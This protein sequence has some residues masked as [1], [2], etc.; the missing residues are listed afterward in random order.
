V[1]TSKKA[2]GALLASNRSAAHEYHLLQRLE[3]GIV[4]A[5]TEVKSA[6]A[7]RVN[8]KDAYAR[9]HDG[10]LWL[11]NAHFSPWTHASQDNHDPLRTRKLLVHARELR[12]L[13]R[14]TTSEG[15]TI[16][17]TRLYLK[18]GRIK[19]EIALA[20]GKK[21]HDKRETEKRREDEREMARARGARER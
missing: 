2:P 19:V 18:G 5:G 12:K 21:Q 15:T 1:S 20:K 3:A 7:G 10:E 13:E 17:P 8:L 14:E 9:V 11:H 4:L 6:R 16:V